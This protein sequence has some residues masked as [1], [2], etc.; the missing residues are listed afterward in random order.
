MKL[1]ATIFLVLP[2]LLAGCAAKVATYN[3]QQDNL[4]SYAKQLIE[5]NRYHVNHRVSFTEGPYYDMQS[6]IV[7]TS[8]H[9]G[10][11]PFYKTMMDACRVEDGNPQEITNATFNQPPAGASRNDHYA[12]TC[13]AAKGA[14]LVQIT[15]IRPYQ[16][17][18]FYNVL[19]LES[20]EP[21]KDF[22]EYL[23]AR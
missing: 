18:M 20:S 21:N 23:Y 6:L 9:M 4:R 8:S 13:R 11:K 12:F 22:T 19:I 7:S 5:T 3:P 15:D 1:K 10:G 17:G 16:L 14:T 2:A